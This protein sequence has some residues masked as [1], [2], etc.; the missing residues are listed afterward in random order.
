ML[1]G[2]IPEEEERVKELKDV[3]KDRFDGTGPA[4][5]D[6][7]TPRR[8]P[9]RLK[10]ETNLGKSKK[11]DKPVKEGPAPLFNITPTK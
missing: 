5:R 10:K 11:K 3:L 1:Q 2:C 4:R 9:T 6:T 7:W 8:E